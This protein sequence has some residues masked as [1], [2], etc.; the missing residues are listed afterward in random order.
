MFI[1]HKGGRT[2]FVMQVGDICQ[3]RHP[4]SI[5]SA[6]ALEFD[7]K[8]GKDKDVCLSGLIPQMEKVEIVKCAYYDTRKPQELDVHKYSIKWKERVFTNIHENDLIP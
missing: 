5:I 2:R 1:D 6:Y 4:E 7:P 3:F 8:S